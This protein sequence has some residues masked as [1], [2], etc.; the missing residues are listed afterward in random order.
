M[1]STRYSLAAGEGGGVAHRARLDQRVGDHAAPAGVA[2]A[3]AM[4]D[5]VPGVNNHNIYSGRLS[6]DVTPSAPLH[7]FTVAPVGR[8]LSG[9]SY[10]QRR[11][12]RKA[13][14]ERPCA[15]CGHLT[16]LDN[17]DG[18]CGSVPVLTSA[19]HPNGWAV[20]TCERY[21]RPAVR[22]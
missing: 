15:A 14:A 2:R 7:A 16:H 13:A 8:S 18:P 1:L 17:P 19:E 9:L 11:R 20:C 3:G 10:T 21:I 6:L 22:Q 5:E 4:G 12:A